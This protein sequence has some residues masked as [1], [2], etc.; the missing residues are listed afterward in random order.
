M[1]GV[2]KNIVPGC[3][4]VKTDTMRSLSLKLFAFVLCFCALAAKGK[5]LYAKCYVRKHGYL[6]FS[7][8][9]LKRKLGRADLWWESST[10]MRGT[11][12]VELV[13]RAPQ[14]KD[15]YRFSNSDYHGNDA[16]YQGPNNHEV[17]EDRKIYGCEA[18]E[19]LVFHK[20]FLFTL[21]P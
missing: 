1:L 20:V 13:G 7:E 16:D 15:I 2:I 17:I 19:L 14:R 21:Q 4:K 9:Y 18:E 6:H 3:N 5:N 10:E 12:K 11:V 8:N